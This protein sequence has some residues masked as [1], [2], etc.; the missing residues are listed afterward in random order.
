MTEPY[1]KSAV[2]QYGVVAIDV[3][4]IVHPECRTDEEVQWT[5][6]FLKDVSVGTRCGR[7]GGT[8]STSGDP[9]QVLL[10]NPS[11]Q[12]VQ[13]G[14]KNPTCYICNDPEFAQMGLPL[15]TACPECGAHVPADDCVCDNGHDVMDLHFQALD[16]DRERVMAPGYGMGC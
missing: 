14:P 9:A 2:R 10:R 4:E 15:C 5:V 7:C 11:I 16:A 13:R 3:G 6:T 1:D 8:I 12:S